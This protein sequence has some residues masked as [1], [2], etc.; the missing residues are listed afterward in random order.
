LFTGRRT[1]IVK[2]TIAMAVF[3]ILLLGI[4]SAQKRNS[5][6]LL[7]DK[8]MKAVALAIEDEVY[9]RGYQKQFYMVGPEV[10]T[11]VTRLPL[12][13]KADAD[14]NGGTVV[15]KLMPFGEVVRD[16]YF[17]KD[18]FAVLE[19]DPDGGFPPTDADTLTLYMDDDDICRWKRTR[20]KFYFEIIDSPSPERI[21][22][23]AVRQ[24]QRV[25]YSYPE[26]PPKEQRQFPPR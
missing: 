12:Y 7:S 8:Q 4:S 9:D 22:E 25:G 2:Q 17:T 3:A 16:F 21:K 19:G 11:G 20:D 14:R 18:G 23:A 13:I 6:P 1:K 15:Y 26:M 10:I 5:A 24:K